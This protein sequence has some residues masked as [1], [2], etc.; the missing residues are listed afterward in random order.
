MQRRRLQPKPGRINFV[1]AI[2]VYTSVTA[3]Q[4]GQVT[5]IV[6]SVSLYSAAE[7]AAEL[8]SA[9]AALRAVGGN[10]LIASGAT[11]AVN[12]Q[13]C[14]GATC[15]SLLNPSST[16]SPA[17]LSAGTLAAI[18]VG[19]V[20]FIATAIFATR[21]IVVRKCKAGTALFALTPKTAAAAYRSTYSKLPDQTS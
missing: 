17:T 1:M 5:A 9:I 3:L 7:L 2:T 8:S 6:V 16:S 15:S 21:F 11:V 20:L 14:T 19:S 18:T 10:P 4:L 13:T 12:G